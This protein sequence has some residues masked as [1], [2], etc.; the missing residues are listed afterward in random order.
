ME[1]EDRFDEH[2]EGGG[3]IVAM[4]DVAV[5]VGDDGVELRRGQ[6]SGD[7]GGQPGDHAANAEDSGLQE[8]ACADSG[9]KA[10]PSDEPGNGEG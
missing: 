7:A 2:V 5:F 9:A 1:P 10:T 8:R 6:S 4:A 3:E